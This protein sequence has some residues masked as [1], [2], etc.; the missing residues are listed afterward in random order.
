MQRMKLNSTF[1]LLFITISTAMSQD[2][3][4]QFNEMVESSETYNEYKVIQRT[5][6]NSFWTTVMDSIDTYRNEEIALNDTINRKDQ[7]INQLESSLKEANQKLS[8]SDFEKTHL[9]FIGIDIKENTFVTIFWIVV[10]VLVAAIIFFVLR[11]SNSMKTTSRKIKDYELLNEEYEEYK[12]RNLEKERKIKRDLQTAV[13]RYE[14]LR[15]K[16]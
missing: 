16:R 14:E 10:I 8:Q 9:N 7:K 1:L 3:N 13:N 2:L 15:K 5:K 11:Y 6:L 12:R 4:S